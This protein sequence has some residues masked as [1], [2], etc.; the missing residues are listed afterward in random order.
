[1]LPLP[2]PDQFSKL[3][4]LEDI[5]KARY[6]G[7]VWGAGALGILLIS[8]PALAQ[9]G[10]TDPNCN[11]TTTFPNPI[12]LAGSSAFE[13]VVQ[14]MAVLLNDRKAV[15]GVTPAPVTLISQFTS[16]CNGPAAI[17]D[18]S[19]LSGKGTYYVTVGGVATKKTCNLDAA[20]PKVDV[21]ISDIF[22]ETCGF[23][24]RPAATIGDF[25]GPVQAM[26]II[27]PTTSQAPSAITAEEAA[28]VWGCGSRAGVAPWIV[29]SAIQYRNSGSG[30]QNIIA[31]SIDILASAFR[32]TTNAT[33]GALVTTLLNQNSLVPIADPTTAIGFLAADAYDST[34]NRPKLRSLAF[35][36]IGQTL[37]Y[38]ADS[39]PDAFDKRNVRDGHYLPWGYEHLIA[40]VDATGKPTSAAAKNFIDW[41]QGNVTTDPNKPNFDPIQVEAANHTIPVC[42]MQVQRASDG[43]FLS[44]YKPADSC[45]CFF[46]SVAN[47]A[48]PAGCVA[49]TSDAGC[50]TAGQKCHHNFCE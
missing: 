16:S 19:N 23:G 10:G 43:G 18:N 47:N 2:R 5:M 1:L 38:Y 6:M 42:A 41:V 8:G 39:A 13:P 30:T 33:G 11:E 14:A 35:R 27:V 20:P 26:L 12:Y 24:T 31:R 36:G 48:T 15:D 40:A 7:A 34:T 9:D 17:K 50:T 29:D 21:G 49:C 37:A 25:P 22:Y 4:L 32:G 46:E 45:S 28:D 3:N 44:A